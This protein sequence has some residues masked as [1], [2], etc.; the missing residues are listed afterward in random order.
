MLLNPYILPGILFVRAH[1]STIGKHGIQDRCDKEQADSGKD[2]LVHTASNT[3]N[4]VKGILE[5]I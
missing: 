5:I 4:L 2:W 3:Q 1:V